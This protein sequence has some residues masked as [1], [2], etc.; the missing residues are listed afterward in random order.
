VRELKANAN[1]WRVTDF[2]TLGSPLAHAAVLL[3]KDASEL[4]A[5]QQ[6]REFPTAPPVTETITR[7][8]RPLTRFSFEPDGKPANPFRVAHHAAVF[9]AT[10][11]TNLYFPCKLIVWGDVVGGPLASWFGAGIKDVAVK[12]GLRWGFFSHTLYWKQDKSKEAT[13]V[14]ELRAAL[15]LLDT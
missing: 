5:K 14:T 9:A 15:N 2:V 11:W 6:A 13:H 12:T 1:P 4:A 10:R 7:Q 8:G 3:A